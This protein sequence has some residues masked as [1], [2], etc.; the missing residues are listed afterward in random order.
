MVEVAVKPA[1]EGTVAEPK[2]RA[3]V[4]A[5]VPGAKVCIEEE[6]AAVATAAALE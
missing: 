2:A 4:E 6:A 3:A 5:V 1:E